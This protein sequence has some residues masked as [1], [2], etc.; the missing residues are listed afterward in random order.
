MALWGNI[1]PSGGTNRSQF[2]SKF[3]T[4]G[5]LPEI[6]FIFRTFYL[7]TN[8]LYSSTKNFRKYQLVIALITC[9]IRYIFCKK[10]G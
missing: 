9:A 10:S 6:E 7:C 4:Y 2:Q 1:S 5:D 3:V 8:A